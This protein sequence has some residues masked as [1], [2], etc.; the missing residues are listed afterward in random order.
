MKEYI[1]GQM[2]YLF[3]KL[4]NDIKSMSFKEH[5]FY[6]MMPILIIGTL[7]TFYFS[8]NEKL[9]RD[10]QSIKCNIN[11]GINNSLLLTSD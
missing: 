11:L 10:I 5:L 9:S 4:S 3:L 7:L 2:K 1:M 8:K 6:W